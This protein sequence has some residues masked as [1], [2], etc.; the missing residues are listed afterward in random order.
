MNATKKILD[1]LL[2]QRLWI[3]PAVMALWMSHEL[4]PMFD[5]ERTLQRAI[6]SPD[7][8]AARVALVV[9]LKKEL[10]NDEK[11]MPDLGAVFRWNP[12]L[13]TEVSFKYNVNANNPGV[14]FG[15]PNVS[16]LEDRLILAIGLF[17]VAFVGS[18]TLLMGTEIVA[19]RSSSVG[20][21][22]ATPEP[23]APQIDATL[24]NQSP[25]D[26]FK[27]DVT[28]SSYRAN[29]LFGRSTLLLFGGV[30]MAF[31]GVSIFYVTLPN[32]DELKAD[33]ALIPTYLTKAIRPTGVLVFVESIA[34]FL[35]RQYRALVEDYKWFYRLY[36][37]RS[38]YLA[39]MR[40]VEK[41]PVQAEDLLIA[42]ALIHEDFSGRLKSGETTEAIE[43]L[44]IPEDS[45]VTEILSAMSRAANGAMRTHDRET[46]A[47][48]KKRREGKETP[49]SA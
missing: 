24:R 11:R 27:A 48:A 15:A 32:T 25:S 37:K 3:L 28:A 31:I 43:A 34:W 45:P 40:I 33:S 23:V 41:K 6:T 46:K 36:L 9:E 12:T 38:N 18:R 16:I 8:A 21:L 29:M 20:E 1:L 39:A 35:L 42:A 4:I 49:D 2:R 13:L 10:A 17:I 30:V 47:R 5:Q 19:T 22:S 7:F 14:T 26:L 44:R